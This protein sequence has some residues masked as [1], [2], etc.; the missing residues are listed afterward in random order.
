MDGEKKRECRWVDP[1]VKAT[2]AFVEWTEDGKLRHSRFVS[3][4]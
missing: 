2:V 1:K 3:I 4:S